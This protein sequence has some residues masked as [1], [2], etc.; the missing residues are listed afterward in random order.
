MESLNRRRLSALSILERANINTKG[1]N[2]TTDI[3][4]GINEA[5]LEWLRE[6]VRKKVER[7]NSQEEPV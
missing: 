2:V 1:F 7:Q 4:S 6:N 5:R 3:E